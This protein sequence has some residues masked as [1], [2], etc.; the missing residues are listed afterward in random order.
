[1][2]GLTARMRR[3]TAIRMEG[4]MVDVQKTVN[5]SVNATRLKWVTSPLTGVKTAA[6]KRTIDD[7]ATRFPSVTK[8]TVAATN[9]GQDLYRF[10]NQ[11]KRRKAMKFAGTPATR[12]RMGV[13]APN[14]VRNT[15]SPMNVPRAAPMAA[16]TVSQTRARKAGRKIPTRSWPTCQ[17]VWMGAVTALPMV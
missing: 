5:P 12:L 17:G 11:P 2:R 4:T 3:G 13:V 14:G 10:T 9:A 15:T 1:M 7:A 16:G 8:E 6:P